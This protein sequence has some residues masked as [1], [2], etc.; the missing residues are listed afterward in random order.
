[1]LRSILVLAAI[2]PAVGCGTL[3]NMQGRPD[4]LMSIPGGESQP[5]GGVAN[6]VRWAGEEY[7]RAFYPEISGIAPANLALA[8][9]FAFV[10]VPLSVV[11]D[12]LTLPGVVWGGSGISIDS[13]WPVRNLDDRERE[14]VNSSG[15]QRQP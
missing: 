8:G 2:V 11:G 3:V 13:V 14:P 7:E 12:V 5:F 15:G 1:M 6:S 4:A 9:Y 10:D